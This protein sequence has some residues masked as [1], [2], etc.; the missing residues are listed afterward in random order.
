MNSDGSSNVKHEEDGIG[1]SEIDITKKISVSKSPLTYQ[2]LASRKH[3]FHDNPIDVTIKNKDIL[4]EYRLVE[5]GYPRMRYRTG[6][7]RYG[8]KTTASTRRTSAP[9]EDAKDRKYY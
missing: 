5:N 2:R 9:N 7:H 8:Q 6:F 3:V 1:D 4:P